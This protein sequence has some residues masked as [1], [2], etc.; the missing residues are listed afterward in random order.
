MTVGR[1]CVNMGFIH[2]EGERAETLNRV[3]KKETPL[4]AAD[5]T[6]GL[7]IRATR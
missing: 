3:D 1:Q 4:S 6:D 7:Y 5:L 2:I